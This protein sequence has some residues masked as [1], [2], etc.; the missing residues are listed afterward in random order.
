MSEGTINERE[1][2]EMCNTVLTNRASI[3]RDRD[4][5]HP[6]LGDDVALLSY[7]EQMVWDKVI[8]APRLLVGDILKTPAE[9]YHEGIRV[10]VDKYGDPPFNARPIVDEMLSK[11]LATG[12]E[13][14]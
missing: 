5:K 13:N 14:T 6:G 4:L 3:W 7:L 1:F 9:N 8:H 2:R 10:K 11:A 12:A